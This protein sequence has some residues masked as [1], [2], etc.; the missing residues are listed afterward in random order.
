MQAFAE[1]SNSA[2]KVGMLGLA[3]I[4]RMLRHANDEQ[5]GFS[6]TVT[7]EGEPPQRLYSVDQVFS[8]SLYAEPVTADNPVGFDV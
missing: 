2:L 1:T 3:I 8:A 6:A 5:A 7:I 4:R